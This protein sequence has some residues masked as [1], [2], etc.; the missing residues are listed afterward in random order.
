MKKI[1]GLL[2]AVFMSVGCGSMQAMSAET[3]NNLLLGVATGGIARLA[4]YAL[5]DQGGS[6][7]NQAMIGAGFVAGVCILAAQTRNS[8]SF[9]GGMIQLAAALG[10]YVTSMYVFRTT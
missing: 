10:T 5:K 4:S 9:N 7:N 6:S 8:G 2:A 3:G 1:Y